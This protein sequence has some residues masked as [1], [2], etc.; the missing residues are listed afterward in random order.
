MQ[1]WSIQKNNKTYV[2]AI[3]YFYYIVKKA[4]GIYFIK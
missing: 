2:N 4:I 1:K 3:Y